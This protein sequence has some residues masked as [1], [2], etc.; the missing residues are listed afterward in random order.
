MLWLSNEGKALRK[1]ERGLYIA[2]AMLAS[3]DLSA[4]KGYCILSAPAA[5][6]SNLCPSGALLEC[7]EGEKLFK[8]P[9]PFLLFTRVYGEGLGWAGKGKQ[10][11]S[12]KDPLRITQWIPSWEP[13]MWL[14]FT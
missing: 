14:S 1:W 10:G 6:S 2:N 8:T 5:L 9:S 12:S 4:E 3:V 11:R 7:A 13:L